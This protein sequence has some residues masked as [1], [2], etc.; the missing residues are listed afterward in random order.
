MEDF[1]AAISNFGFPIVV[2]TFLLVRFEKKVEKL[3]NSIN[4]RD[5]LSA[6]IKQLSRKIEDVCKTIE[7]Q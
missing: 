1:F 7:R 5:G 2:A 6:Q 3:E 4:G